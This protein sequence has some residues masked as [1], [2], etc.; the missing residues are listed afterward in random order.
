MTE[1]KKTFPPV[2][3]FAFAALVV[4]NLSVFFDYKKPLD[5]YQSFA[6]VEHQVNLKAGDVLHNIV[7]NGETLAKC[8]VAAGGQLQWRSFEQ[9]LVNYQFTPSVAEAPAKSNHDAVCQQGDSIK[10]DTS[11]EDNHNTQLILLSIDFSKPV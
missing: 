3:W 10:V 6:K 7:R 9:Q 4:L 1:N 11:S 8:T 5:R 2:M